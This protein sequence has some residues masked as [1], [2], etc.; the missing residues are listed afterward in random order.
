M[1]AIVYPFEANQAPVERAAQT[2]LLSGLS[3]GRLGFRGLALLLVVCVLGA[4]L[5]S[6]CALIE[7]ENRHTM[8]AVAAFIPESTTWRILSSPIWLVAGLG[9]IIIDGFVLNPIFNANAALDDA[10]DWAFL[11]FGVF[12]PAEI[13]LIAPRVVAA[14]L[15]FIV[16]EVARCTI[17]HVF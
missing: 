7:E 1:N 12:L 2:S 5:F 15:I 3:R 16:S 13:I 10:L 6:G 8:K 17:P 11:G 9:A 14:V 4:G